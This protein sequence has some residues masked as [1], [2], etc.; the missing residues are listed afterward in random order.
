MLSRL[1]IKNFVIIDEIELDF[2]HGFNVITGETG[3]GKS[4]IIGAILQIA[5]NRMTQNLIKKDAEKAIIQA[6]FFLNNSIFKDEYGL[7]ENGAGE[8]IIYRELHKSGK[9]VAKI[10]GTMVSNQL[11][12]SVSSELISVFGQ[13]DK[14]KLFDDKEQLKILDSFVV[15]QN[16]PI[17]DEVNQLAKTY[18]NLMIEREKLIFSDNTAIEREREL[19]EY[20]MNDI[21]NASLREEDNL[22]EEKFEKA[23]NSMQIIDALSMAS[24]HL[25]NDEKK[26]VLNLLSSIINSINQVSIY[27]DEYTKVIENLEDIR[28]SLIDAK[29]FLDK[30][31]ENINDDPNE[32]FELEK[33]LDEINLLKKKYGS[34]LEEIIAFREKLDD[35]LNDLNSV[36]IRNEQLEEEI[37]KVEKLYFEKA[38]IISELRKEKAIEISND[39]SNNLKELN[40]KTA[41]FKIDFKNTEKVDMNGFDSIKFMVKINAGSDFSELKKVAS[42]GELSRIML[43]IQE[44]IAKEYNI[45]VLI[46]D[47]ID[48]GISGRSANLLAKK[49]YKVSLS[50]QLIVVTHLLQVA[51]YGDKHYLIEKF[52][53]D[54]ITKTHF[55]KLSIDERAEE[56]YRLISLDDDS[57][58]L[59]IESKRLIASTEEAK[60]EIKKAMLL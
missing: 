1:I 39:I 4:L 22:I 41:Q 51:L 38:K 37:A 19:I 10:N 28:Y 47:E 35:R 3:A 13:N 5:G 49:L 14:I 11:L 42:G 46:F 12:R 9:S 44:S 32:I 20:Q 33:R 25:D 45:P 56:I 58:E 16:K 27:D 15:P 52:D 29:Y 43:A 6:Q 55:K 23:K 26:S 57:E 40:F 34:S 31:L 36:H 54:N 53:K 30:Q 8:L 60:Q 21:D 48:T 2:E 59:K 7:D 24:Y 18:K 17:Y 50:H